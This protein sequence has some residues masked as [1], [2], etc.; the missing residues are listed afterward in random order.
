VTQIPTSTPQLKDNTEALQ[1]GWVTN[2]KVIRKVA[3]PTELES[4]ETHVETKP[5]E[6]LQDGWDK[7][8]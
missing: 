2:P 4:P 8:K 5:W 3:S 7:H 1:D 6:I